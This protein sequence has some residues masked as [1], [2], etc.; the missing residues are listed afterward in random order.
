VLGV[1]FFNPA[2]VMPL[3]ELVPG[4]TTRPEVLAAV[5]ACVERWGKSPV[6]ADD[7][8][9]FIVNRIA[10]PFYGEALRILEER[11]ADAATIDWAMRERGFRMGP[12]ELMDFIGN[13]V[14]YAVTRSVWEAFFYDP[15]Y[16]PSFTQRRLVEAGFLGRKTGRGH[17]DHTTTARPEP[18]RD[19]GLG[20]EIFERILAMLVNE[21]ADAVQTGVASAADVE[22][23]MTKGVNYP[24]GLLAWG[25]EYGL[26]RLTGRLEALRE[27]YQEDRY[28]VS[29]LLRRTARAG[30]R[31]AP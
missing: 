3:V 20:A 2:P 1:H 13:D 23:A 27:E 28:R 12:F 9:G 8:P 18:V 31:L 30:G 24:K 7:T 17:Y 10:R 29:P 21:A 26:D 4:L 11:I 5:R 16:R 15:R 6:V 19:E 14:N 22:L 25:D